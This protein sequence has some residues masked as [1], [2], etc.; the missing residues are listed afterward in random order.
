MARIT[1]LIYSLIC[2]VLFNAVFLYLAAFLLEI[3]VSK[4][5][6]SGAVGH[7]LPAV[8]I[9]IGLVVLFGA[10]HSI[11]ARD[12]FKKWLIRFV[13]EVAERSTYVLQ[14]SLFLALVIWQWQPMPQTIWYVEGTAAWSFYAVFGLGVIML[15][16]STFLIDHFELF[17]LHQVWCYLQSKEMPEPEFRTPVL[18]RIVR[19]PMQLG[20]IIM[21]LATPHMTVGHLLFASLMCAYI[22]IGLYFEERSLVRMFGDEY[23]DYQARVPMLI[24]GIG[25][26]LPKVANQAH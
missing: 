17:G 18:Y 15:L 2:Y 26:V 8:V 3:G 21:F 16:W 11:M 6:N 10:T 25:G 9:N 19:H 7:W 22:S 12:W 4:T 24:P 1:T 23:R 5:I 13:P 20:V 14:A